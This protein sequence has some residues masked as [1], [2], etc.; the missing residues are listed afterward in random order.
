MSLRRTAAIIRKEMLHIVRDPRN[1]FLVIVSPSFLLLLLA[2]LF[3]FE[4]G[5]FILAVLDQDR[6]ELSRSFV[7][8]IGSDPNLSVAYWVDDYD[9][10]LPLLV[11]GKADTGL[12][13]PPGFGARLQERR[14]VTVQ[15]ILDGTDPFDA[16]QASSILAAQ[17]DIFAAANAGGPAGHPAA[18]APLEVRTTTWYNAGLESLHSMVPALLAVVLLMP[19]LALALALTREKE[20]GTLEGLFATPVSGL[21]YTLGKLL[22]YVVM[23]LVSAV[24]AL[25]VAVWWFKVPFRG[26]LLIYLLL[27]STYYLACMG[28][29]A[30]IA[31]FVKSQQTAMFVVLI[32]F[33]VPSFFLSGLITPVSTAS[34]A[35]A[36]TSYSMPST[37]FVEISRVVFLKGLGLAYL[38]RPALALLVTGLGSLALAL[39]LFKK[40]IA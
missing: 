36:L 40:K 32:I 39:L 19:T 28:T 27:S 26:S 5:Q 2:H 11:G 33:L 37:H 34:R 23:G 24:L 30:V 10:I 14:T 9:A 22:T 8:S 4:G 31:S 13:I 17:A 7:H 35:A 20:S 21:E 16:S 3:T 29:A 6:T 25:L 38:V 15:A 18:L 12:V 1:L